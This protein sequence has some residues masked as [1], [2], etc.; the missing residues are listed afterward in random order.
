[1]ADGGALGT[2]AGEHGKRVK[3]AHLIYVAFRDEPDP[4]EKI[5]QVLAL[6]GGGRGAPPTQAE[7]WRPP[8][9]GG[10]PPPQGGGVWGGRAAPPP[11]MDEAR[12]FAKGLWHEVL[13]EAV[14]E[15]RD[16]E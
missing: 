8:P 11:T 15:A 2:I 12:A 10:Q 3:Q 6:L 1:M 14:G 9:P 7:A 5:A 13:V 4:V 16:D